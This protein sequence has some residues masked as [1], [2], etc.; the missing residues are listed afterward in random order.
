M[1]RG[2][3]SGQFI[4]VQFIRKISGNCQKKWV[5][6]GNYG[7]GRVG[8]GRAGSGRAGSGRAVT[9]RQNFSTTFRKPRA[10]RGELLL[11][12]RTFLI[13]DAQISIPI[14]QNFNAID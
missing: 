13:W 14:V 12:P 10:P 11:L 3:G 1:I 9:N 4:R 7:A 6:S 5:G 2:P 8:P